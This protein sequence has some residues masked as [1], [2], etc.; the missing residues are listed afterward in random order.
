MNPELNTTYITLD[1]LLAVQKYRYVYFFPLL[2]VYIL[3]LCCNLIIVF[4]ICRHKSLHE[5]MYVFIAALLL[6][7]AFFSTNIY[8]KLLSDILSEKQ[9]ISYS[10]CLFQYFL[11]YSL[12]GSEYLLLSAM[13]YD[14]YVS[15][16]RPL[17]YPTI[18]RKSTVCVLLCLAWIV[19]ACLVGVTTTLSSK[20]KICKWVLNAIFCNNSHYNLHC[21]SSDARIILVIFG[22]VM[23]ALFPVFFILFTY[24]RILI[25]SYR[26]CREVRKKAAHT[27]LPHLLVLVSF[28]LLCT[29][30]VVIVRL[31]TDLSKLVRLLMTFQA[32]LY[33]PLF[34]PIVYGL[35]MKEISKHLKRLFC[36]AKVI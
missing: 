10:A 31:G 3:I 15:I 28:S 32:I 2:T 24:T 19:P 16:C 1:G 6:N 18:M 26:S 5:P 14:R 4:L 27:C 36:Q 13:A 29:Y 33:H 12:A 11:F 17:H 34:N 30:D 21:E 7:A 35:K 9:L 25:I 22:M 8:P 23:I 20:M